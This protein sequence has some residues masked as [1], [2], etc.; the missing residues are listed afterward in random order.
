MKRKIIGISIAVV[1]IGVIAAAL[2]MLYPFVLDLKDTE[3]LLSEAD[4]VITVAGSTSSSDAQVKEA[5]ERTVAS[6][7][8]AHVEKAVKQ[9]AKELYDTMTGIEKIVSDK[10]LNNVLDAENLKNDGNTFTKSKPLVE[11]AKAELEAL[12][13]KYK[14]LQTET[15]AL[16]FAE[17]AGIEEKYIPLYK[18]ATYEIIT[19]KTELM[20]G[21]IEI[22]D[23]TAA[24]LDVATQVLDL[25]STNSKKW[26][27]D[28]ETIVFYDSELQQAYHKLID[29]LEE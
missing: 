11:N 6:E 9:Y 24:F 1:I 16:S 15:Y 5:L 14:K 29:M 4:W 2:F 26:Y 20:A 25:L 21:N 27:M 3:K 7:K 8:F 13:E 18:S 23:G 19:T 10:T 17:S 22:M 12:R 28:G